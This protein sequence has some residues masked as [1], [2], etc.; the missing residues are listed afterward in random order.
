M[1][2]SAFAILFTVFKINF[3]IST[4]NTICIKNI[5]NMLKVSCAYYQHADTLLV[6]SLIILHD[7]GYLEYSQFIEYFRQ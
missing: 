3:Q 7:K 4:I 5:L 1:K 6:T 2:L